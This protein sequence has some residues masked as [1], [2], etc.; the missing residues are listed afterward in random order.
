MKNN[1]NLKRLPTNER[2]F[3]KFDVVILGKHNIES[4]EFFSK[5]FSITIDNFKYKF[6]NKCGLCIREKIIFPKNFINGFCPEIIDKM[7]NID[8]LILTY[9]SSNKLSFEMIKRFYYLYYSKFEE[10]EKPK[11]IIIIELNSNSKEEEQTDDAVFNTN[12]SEQLKNLFKGHFYNNADNEQNLNEIFK[13]CVENLKYIY[14]FKDN[15]GFFKNIELDKEI[16]INIPIYGE[17]ELLNIFMKILS[18]S[19][20]NFEFK[21]FN[22]F[23]NNIYEAKYNTTINGIIYNFKINFKLKNFEYFKNDSLCIIFLYDINDINS[24]EKI[25]RIIRDNILYNDSFTK[26]IFNLFSFNSKTDIIS[27]REWIKREKQGKMLSDEIGA[28]FSAINNINNQNLSEEMKIKFDKIFEEIINCVNIN[29]ST[30]ENKNEEKIGVDNNFYNIQKIDSPLLYANEINNIIKNKYKANTNFLNNICPI[31]YNYLDIKIN[32]ISNIIII[33]CNN[34]KTEPRGLNI[35]QYYQLNK[36]KSNLTHCNKCQNLLNYEL[37]SKKL[38]CTCG[39]SDSKHKH[40]SKTSRN[41]SIP[42]ILKNSFCDIHNKFHKYYMKYSKKR[43]CEDCIKTLNEKYYFIEEFNENEANELINKKKLELDKE[44]NFLDSLQNKFSECINT[45]LIKFQKLFENKLKMHY[46]KSELINSL[47]IIQ[48]NYTIVSNVKSLKFDTGKNFTYNIDDS[49][50]KRIKSLFNYLKCDFDINSLY[51]N[52]PNNSSNPYTSYNNL[53]SKEE[54]K[55]TDICGI[56]NNKLICVGYNDGQAKIYDLNIEEKNTYPRCIIKEFLPNQGVNSI[57]VS[58]NNILKKNISNKNEIIYLNGY[59]EIKFIQMN[60]NYDSYEVLYNIR[61]E[62]SNIY[63]S[64]DID[65]NNILMLTN[66][67][68]LKLIVLNTGE[69]KEITIELKDITNLI[70]HSG[71][72]PTSLNKITENIVSLTISSFNNN[73][74]FVVVE[75][76][77]YIDNNNNKKSN[78]KLNR[79]FTLEIP[80]NFDSRTSKMCGLIDLGVEANKNNESNKYIKILYLNKDNYKLKEGENSLSNKNCNNLSIKKEF[81]F[82]KNFT[83]LGCISEADNLLLLN[84]SEPNNHTLENIIYIFDFNI[85]QFIDAFIFHCVFTLPILLS[86]INYENLYDKN[87]FILCDK[88]LNYV[89]FFYDKNYINRIY[90]IKSSKLKEKGEQNADKIVALDNRI[91]FLCS[92][93]EYYIINLTPK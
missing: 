10:K 2:K 79:H 60:D 58:K 66:F 65:Y 15:Y 82:D 92:N 76:D 13:Q 46:I 89:Q 18:A 41:Q 90:Y 73:N 16:D 22:T 80:E 11:N 28:N 53:I 69:D 30:T 8:I 64:I 36:E 83:L 54:T 35:N 70:I 31:C 47:E 48:N 38:F 71:E 63:N 37:K 40:N 25:T 23:Y 68:L 93:K 29:K 56:N 57:Y 43:L 7:K 49:I 20:C 42:I 9:N 51:F 81:T 78:Q 12:N 77:N 24:Y 84:Y 33:Y 21:K 39:N 91:V 3:S 45:L 27:E 61:D 86:K 62:S 87:G 17:Q 6:I 19:K 26:I 85:C 44:K 55:I 72:L 88:D 52:S 14:N 4:E 32:D 50:E 67:D 1:Q 34:C 5:A 59:E 74:N 75:G